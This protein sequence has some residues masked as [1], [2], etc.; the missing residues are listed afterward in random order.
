MTAEEL[1]AL[2]LELAAEMDWHYELGYMAGRAGRQREQ[3]QPW[4]HDGAG[5]R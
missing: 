2:V 1:R 3:G 5:F 4:G